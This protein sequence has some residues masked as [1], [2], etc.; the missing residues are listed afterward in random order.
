MVAL[1]SQDA[2]PSPSGVTYAGSAMTKIGSTRLFEGNL[3]SVSLWYRVLGTSTAGAK[4]IV[5][6]FS[7]VQNSHMVSCSTYSG[8]HQ[9][10]PF[11]S[12][13]TNPNS[14]VNFQQANP[15]IAS[16]DVG[17]VTGERV[18]AIASFTGLATLD[19]TT[20]QTVLAMQ[21]D[22]ANHS[23]GFSTAAGATSSVTMSWTVA[24]GAENGIIGVSIQEATLTAPSVSDT[25]TLTEAVTM[26][27]KDMPQVS[28]VVTV[29]ETQQMHMGVNVRM[30]KR[31]T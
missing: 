5:A 7:Q 11:V 1:T 24:Q 23:H 14:D 21:R 15:A 12:R 26:N 8:V 18:F 30:M 3:N 31:T 9:T 28:D 25:A 19:P 2:V 13:A 4:A 17:S 22:V 16:V 6:T 29:T 20:S 10:I 27:V